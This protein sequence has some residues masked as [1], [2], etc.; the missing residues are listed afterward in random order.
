MPKLQL[1]IVVPDALAGQRLDRTLAK[2]YLEHS[3]VRIQS[4]I[5]AGD[6]TVNKTIYRQRDTVNSGDVI[7]IKTKI[8]ARHEHQAEAIKLNIVH[9]DEA[10]III[11]KPAGLVVHPGAGNP[12]H[13]L[14]NALLHFDES[15]AVVPRAGIIHRLD[16]DTSGLLV[17]ARTLPS[18]T[19]L[20]KQLQRRAIKREYQAIV[21]GQLISGGSITNKIGRH[22]RQRIKMAITDNGKIATTHYRIIKKYKHYTHLHVQLETGRTHQI[23]VHLAHIKHPIVGDPVYGYHQSL[24]KGIDASLRNIISHCNRQALHAS[25]LTLTHPTTKQVMQFIAELPDA[26][27]TLITALNNDDATA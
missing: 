26:M 25:A 7:E 14:V 3:R 6:V 15:L 13:T 16:K 11:N 19:A 24:R 1:K 4:W 23:R 27:Q 5:K 21:C 18:H 17:I 20:V 22:P 2:L 10:F 8:D 9:E 12:D